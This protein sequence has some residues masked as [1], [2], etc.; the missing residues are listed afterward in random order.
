LFEI[1]IR[2]AYGDRYRR[3]VTPTPQ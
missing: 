2:Y 1:T 3:T